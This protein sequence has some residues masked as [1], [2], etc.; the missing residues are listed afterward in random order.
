MSTSTQIIRLYPSPSLRS[1]PL[2]GTP[3]RMKSHRHFALHCALSIS[4]TTSLLTFAHYLDCAAMME[5]CE[6]VFMSLVGSAGEEHA[7]WLLSECLQW[8][9]R[10]DRYHLC[11]YKAACIEIIAADAQIAEREKYKEAKQL[12]DTALTREVMTAWAKRNTSRRR[13]ERTRMSR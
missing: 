6:A 13:T 8:V 4:H 5:Q 7:E 2:T 11:K 3:T 12:W 1:L 10:A 9:F